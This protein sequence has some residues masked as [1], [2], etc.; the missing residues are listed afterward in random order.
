MRPHRVHG[1]A[2][3][4][5]WPDQAIAARELIC[6]CLFLPSHAC[7]AFVHMAA[8]RVGAARGASWAAM[9]FAFS[10]IGCFRP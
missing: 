6:Y 5:Q 10:Q 8:E 3:G 9:G 2:P 4:E 7:T 1:P